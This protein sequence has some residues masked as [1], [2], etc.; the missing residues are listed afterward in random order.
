MASSYLGYPEHDYE[1]ESKDNYCWH[2]VRGYLDKVNGQEPNHYLY[3]FASDNYDI[4]RG[5]RDGYDSTDF[6]AC[7]KVKMSYHQHRLL[8]EKIKEKTYGL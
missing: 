2:Y 4:A 5:Y 1:Q 8:A 7:G 6:I 3:V